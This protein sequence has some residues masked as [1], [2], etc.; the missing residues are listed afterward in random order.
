MI[1]KAKK[2][3]L[4]LI[5]FVF[6]GLVSGFSTYF[7]ESF[8]KNESVFIQVAH[9][10]AIPASSCGA[11]YTQA[12]CDEWI[13]SGFSAVGDAG[14]C[15]AGGASAGGGTGGGGGGGAGS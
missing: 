5:G 12:Q 8:S 4:L 11:G 7:R 6:T 9:A 3:S 13:N 15:D 2:R 10:D 14:C 1:H